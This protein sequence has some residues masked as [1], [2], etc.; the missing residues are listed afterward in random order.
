MMKN[1]KLL[2]GI[3]V[4]AVVAIVGIGLL[5]KSKPSIE[6]VKAR[7]ESSLMSIPGVV[8]VGI[9]EC[10]NSNIPFIMVYLEKE[11]PESKSIPKQL[12]GFKIDV[13]IAGPIE[14]IGPLEH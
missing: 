13:A 12:E 8:G 14:T 3:L 6:D 2:Y 5:D 1:K 11:T 9:S 4:I 10:D 7:H